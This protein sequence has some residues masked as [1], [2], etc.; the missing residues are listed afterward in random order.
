MASDMRIASLGFC[1]A[2]L[3]V[4]ADENSR[5]GERSKDHMIYGKDDVHI[6]KLQQPTS[7]L[8]HSIWQLS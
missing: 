6:R 5:H 8:K 3:S 1:F 7:K 4:V 2:S